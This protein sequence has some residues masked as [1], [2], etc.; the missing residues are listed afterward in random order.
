ML[1]LFSRM[2]SK[3]DYFGDIKKNTKNKINTIKDLAYQLYKNI[4]KKYKNKKRIFIVREGRT[5]QPFVNMISK[6]NKK[7]FEIYIL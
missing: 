6:N 4:L 1:I 2:N 5:Q 7:F 3:L